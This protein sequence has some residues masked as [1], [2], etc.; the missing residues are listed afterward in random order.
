M[1]LRTKNRYN[2]L[3]VPVEPVGFS[4]T[5]EQIQTPGG[6][7]DKEWEDLLLRRLANLW[8]EHMAGKTYSQDEVLHLF[9]GIVHDHYGHVISEVLVK[10]DTT[11]H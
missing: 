2:L 5:L 3:L 6:G 10:N 9:S 1:S 8:N 11:L 4:L 7:R